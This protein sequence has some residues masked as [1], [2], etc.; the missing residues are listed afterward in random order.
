MAVILVA[1]AGAL[2]AAIPLFPGQ[3]FDVGADPVFVAFGDFNNDGRPDLVVAN[4]DGLSIL[5]GLGDGTFG[6]RMHFGSGCRP[7]SIAIRD[8]DGDGRQDLAVP[9]CVADN[10]LAGLSVFGGLGDGTFGPPVFFLTIDQGRLVAPGDFNADGRQDLVVGSP[11]GVSVLLGHGDGTFEPEIRTPGNPVSAIAV[12]DYDGD[13]FPDLALAVDGLAVRLGQGDGTF[14][15]PTRQEMD[16]TVQQV[17]TGDVNGDGD[18]DLVGTTV[19]GQLSVYQGH[20]DGSFSRTQALYARIFGEYHPFTAD[21]VDLNADGVQDLALAS[22]GISVF[23]GRGDGSFGPEIPSWVGKNASTSAAAIGDLD[24]DGLLDSVVTDTNTDEAYVLPGRGDG[25]FDSRMA[26]LMLGYSDTLALVLADVNDDEASDLAVVNQFSNA[27]SLSLGAGD[28]TF[29]PPGLSLASRGDML[30]SVAAGDVNGDGR[31]DLMAGNN[32]LGSGQVSVFLGL[33][34]G[35]FAPAVFYPTGDS[36]RSVVID[37]INGDGRPDLVMAN[38]GFSNSSGVSILLGAG[39]GTFA[40]PSY[41]AP[42]GRS[43]SVAVGDFD[44]NGRRDLVLVYPD[45]RSVAVLLGHAYGAFGDALFLATGDSPQSVVMGDVDGDGHQDLAVV[46]LNSYISLFLGHGDGG[47]DPETRLFPGS[48]STSVAIED[49]DVDGHLDVVAA[50][51]PGD[52]LVLLGLGDGTFGPALRYAGGGRPILVA[53]RDLNHDARPDLVVANGRFPDRADVSVLLNEGPFDS[54][55][56][57]VGSRQ[58]NCPTVYNPDQANSDA[59]RPGDACDNCPNLTALSQSDTDKDGIGD[60][61]DTC[62]DTDRDGLGNPG[63]PA[64]TCTVDNCPTVPNAAQ[65]DGD[66]DGSGDACDNCPVVF[67]PNQVDADLDGIG[68]VCD[69]CMD[70]D[71]DGFGDPGF[72]ANAC[73]L[74]NCPSIRNPG[75][76]DTDGDGPGDAC[77]GCTDTDQ[78]AFGDP[79]FPA[80]TCPIDN[81]PHIVNPAQNDSDHDAV[82]DL[83]DLCMDTDHDGHGDPGFPANTCPPDN[84]PSDFNP[85]QEDADGD[86]QGDLCD[87]CT[88]TD[89]DG[90]GDPGFPRYI[91]TLDNCPH[92]YNPG[93]LDADEDRTGDSCDSCT[94]TDRDGFGDPGLP[95]NTCPVD[96]CPSVANAG[97]EDRD[98]DGPGDLCDVC[99]D[100]PDPGQ[101]DANHDGSGDACQPVLALGAIRRSGDDT[102]EASLAASD[103]Q[104]DPLSG[105]IRILKKPVE[106]DLPDLS[107]DLSCDRGYLPDGAPGRGIGF[108]GGPYSPVVFDLDSNLGCD[109]GA[110]DFGIALGP[111]TGPQTEFGSLLFL[112]GLTPGPTSLL[113]VRPAGAGTGGIDLTVTGLTPNGL[114]VVVGPVQQVLVVGFS[115]GVPGRIDIASLEPGVTYRLS[116]TLTD[117]MTVPVTASVDFPYDGQSTLLLGSPPSARIAA[118]SSV[119]CDRTGGALVTLDGSASDAPAGGI[120]AYE[121]IRD[122]GAPGETPLGTGPIVSAFLPLGAS[123]VELRVTDSAGQIGTARTSITVEDTTPPELAVSATP[124]TLSPADHRLVDVSVAVAASDRCGAA[125]IVLTAA[126]SSEPDDAPGSSDGNTVNDI[127]GASFG[128]AD[129]NVLLR[130]ERDASGPGRVYVLSY[131]AT[132]PSGNTR[133]AT[134]LVRVPHKQ[135]P[136]PR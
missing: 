42:A 51:V 65:Q 37:D 80:S 84:C 64:G 3:A 129:F 52:L 50:S 112:N 59:D 101:E 94:D 30:Y 132:D 108:L 25:H 58:D 127:Q 98:G 126:T 32:Y 62:T 92:T 93:Q 131:A 120:V 121:W 45:S 46:N 31:P 109:D 125:S 4:T 119:E 54:D 28:G 29:A 44:E 17:S 70:A 79:G 53:T 87:L 85:G 14:G 99:P 6:P 36:P 22:G 117:G 73:Q 133:T 86:R 122:P 57:G 136:P 104:D 63:F 67:N 56:D 106:I 130:A 95:A 8:F 41:F 97:Q 19:Y 88:D 82:G 102:L 111:C 135:S 49:L 23:L 43:P 26:V 103:P 134:A 118:E 34:G 7:K 11:N 78:D 18:L 13:G 116:I 33:G 40:P 113:C 72:P 75:Q 71:H 1:P 89:Q 38:G 55:E 16:L 60:V 107:A 69:P 100:A 21:I 123:T 124:A 115:N 76:E 35:A 114:D 61:C 24:G 39:D 15:D 128:T 10:G 20:G 66:L 5:L 74:D 48:R 9:G 2:R 83:C 12:G 90:F 27:I 77:D 47:F 105:T 81:C 68:D 96:N 110:Q 91:C